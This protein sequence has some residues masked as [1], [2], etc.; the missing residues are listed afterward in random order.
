MRHTPRVEREAA[1]DPLPWA[2]N[3][4]GIVGG[5]IGAAHRQIQNGLAVGFVL[6]VEQSIGFGLVL[7][8]KTPLAR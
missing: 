4:L 3:H 6:G 8:A 5:E 2:A 7:G 1:D